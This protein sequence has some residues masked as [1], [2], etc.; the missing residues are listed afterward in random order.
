MWPRT[1]A[2]VLRSDPEWSA[3]PPRCAAGLDPLTQ[4]LPYDKSVRTRV[5]NM[6]TVEVELAE[7]DG[8][9]TGSAATATLYQLRCG[10]GATRS[11]WASLQASS[12]WV[13]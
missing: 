12:C 2:E 3:L 4:A 10:S 1:I 5:A 11:R 13:P 6:A 9:R 8:E 7:A